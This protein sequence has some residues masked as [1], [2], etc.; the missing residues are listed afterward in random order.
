MSWQEWFKAK[1]LPTVVVHTQTGQ[2]IRGALVEA[3]SEV[4]VLRMAALAN[5]SGP[6]SPV[7]WQ[8]LAGDVVIRTENVDFM[9]HGL[10]HSF[11]VM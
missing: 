3:G 10:D 4:Y 1:P 11:L 5:Q 9:Q 6:G 7:S 8:A 2:M